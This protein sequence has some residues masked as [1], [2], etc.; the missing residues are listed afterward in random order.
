[1]PAVYD[2]LRMQSADLSATPNPDMRNKAL[3]V[4]DNATIALQSGNSPKHYHAKSDEIQYIV[5]GSGQM[6]VGNERREIRPGMLIVIPK[7]TPHSGTIVTSGPIKAIS[8]KIPPQGNGDVV[9]VE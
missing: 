3:V 5:E 9:L 7:G 6:W 1:M 2:L 8:I 4:T